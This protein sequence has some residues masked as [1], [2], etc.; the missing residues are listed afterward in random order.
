MKWLITNWICFYLVSTCWCLKTILFG[1]ISFGA[2]FLG[3]INLSSMKVDSSICSLISIYYDRNTV[4]PFQIYF[5]RWT[6]CSILAINFSFFFIFYFFVNELNFSGN[7]S[8]NL[9]YSDIIFLKQLSLW[10]Y[11]PFLSLF[12]Y[13][14]KISIY[15]IHESSSSYIINFIKII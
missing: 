8:A 10:M 7:N 2:T 15:S 6:T 9:Y 5:K 1:K 3:H 4:F 12:L 13:T 11:W 14:L